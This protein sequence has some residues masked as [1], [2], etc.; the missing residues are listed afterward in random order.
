[1]VDIHIPGGHHPPVRA[2]PTDWNVLVLGAWNAAILT[3]AGITRRLFKV[4]PRTPMTVEVAMNQ[5]GSFR[6]IHDEMIVDPT[7]G[8]LMVSPK[9]CTLPELSKAASLVDVAIAALPETPVAAAGV[10]VGYDIDVVSEPLRDLLSEKLDRALSEASYSISQ[11]SSKKTIEFQDGQIN[12]ELVRT[13]EGSGKLTFNFHR[14]SEVGSDLRTWISM[15]APMMKEVSKICSILEVSLDA[16]G[17]P[18]NG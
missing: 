17:T 1:M 16:E 15:T 12:V 14:V 4:D 2:Q 10:N 18:P 13:L 3:P 8:R 5:P 11:Y 9:R 7:G 6:V